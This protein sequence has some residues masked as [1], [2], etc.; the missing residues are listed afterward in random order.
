M[1]TRRGLL[2]STAAVFGAAAA[3]GPLRLVRGASADATGLFP[4]THTD[5]EWKQLLTTDQYNVLRLG[6][7]EL[8]NSSALNEEHRAGLFHC[9]GCD[10]ALYSSET[11]YESGTGWPSFW[12]P[13]AD[14]LLGNTIDYT[15]GYANVEV[16]CATCGGHLGHVYGDGPAPTYERYC[17]NGDALVFKP[18]EVARQG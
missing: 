6:S 2:L 3:A 9:A 8:P 10:T 14:H 13:I 18:G 7:T 17:M 11:K 4:V 1:L 15:E 16:H 5:A 12:A